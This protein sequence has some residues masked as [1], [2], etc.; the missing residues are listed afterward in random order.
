MQSLALNQLAKSDAEHHA[1]GAGNSIRFFVASA[2]PVACTRVF[3][4]V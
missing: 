2:I 4:P 3:G 1:S